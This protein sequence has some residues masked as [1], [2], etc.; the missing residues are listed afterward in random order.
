MI[1]ITLAYLRGFMVKFKLLNWNGYEIRLLHDKD[2]IRRMIN[3]IPYFWDDEIHFTLALRQQSNMKYSEDVWEYKWR[4]LD[5]DGNRIKDKKETIN[6]TKAKFMRR[7]FGGYWTAGKRRAIVLGN[8]SPNKNYILKVL[9]TNGMGE[10]IDETMATF[11]I[12][13]RTDIYMQIFLIL[14]S[15]FAALFFSVVLKGCGL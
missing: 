15:I 12:K 8:L 4:L 14:F 13:D 5:L 9:F 7:V 2:N 6:I 3:L 10:S 1:N 11:S